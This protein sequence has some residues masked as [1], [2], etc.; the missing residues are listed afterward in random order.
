[1]LVAFV[2]AASMTPTP[3]AM[4]MLAVALPDLR[5]V[6][7]RARGLR[8]ARPPG[9]PAPRRRGTARLDGTMAD[10]PGGAA[11]RRVIHLGLV[12]NP[13]AG[14]G[15]GTQAGRR[16]TRPAGAWAQGRGPVGLHARAGD[17][18]GARGGGPGSGRARRGRRRRHGAPRRERRRGNRAA[19]RHRRRG[20]GQRHRAQPRAPARRRR[21]ASVAAVE[22]GSGRRSAARGR[23]PGRARRST[24]RTS[25]TSGSCRAASTPPINARR[26]R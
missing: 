25:G 24:P 15:R 26:T 12:V 8:A 6:L 16:R 3:D 10:E 17:G 14:K 20:D 21:A 19:A 1:M 7:R 11:E 13:T 18:P 22:Q 4:T 5:A 23:R 2:F 9:G